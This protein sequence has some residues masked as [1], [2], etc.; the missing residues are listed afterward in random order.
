M[1]WYEI[2]K[3]VLNIIYMITGIGIGL[4]VF[5]GYKQLRIMKEESEK[6]QY[7]LSVEKSIEYIT[8]FSEEVL[9]VL[10]KY[11]SELVGNGKNTQNISNAY[12]FIEDDY[13]DNNISE[14]E[15]IK[16]G[17]L[18]VFK[19]I[20]EIEILATV[21]NKGIADKDV[22]FETVGK[23]FCEAIEVTYDVIKYFRSKGSIKLFI[24]TEILYKEW[25]EEFGDIIF[26]IT[27][28]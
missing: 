19:I 5:I 7:R 23:N 28:Q 18:G 27:A 8:R 21:V 26:T 22:M 1:V 6:T 3:E 17:K 24:N 16:L 9:P 13:D 4:T 25:K 11:E 15:V 14:D 10:K 12:A 2:L 20:N